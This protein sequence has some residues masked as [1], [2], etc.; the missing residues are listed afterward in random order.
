MPEVIRVLVVDDHA[1]HRDGARGILS[2]H[3][4]IEVVDEADSG[5]MALA[6]IDRLLPDVVL[7]DIRLPGVSGIE[8]TRQIRA[9]NPSVRVLMVSAYD[10][11]EY[12][13]GALQAGASGYLCKTAPGREL[14]KAIRSVASGSTVVEPAV[15]ARLLVVRPSRSST[16]GGLSER[17]QSVLDLLAQGLTNKRVAARLNISART[18]ERHCESIYAK[19]AVHSRAEAV[20]SGFASGLLRGRHEE[21]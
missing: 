12:I 4:D 20:I 10:D 1:L 16:E 17:E 15:L 21:P 18:V 8:A 13:R 3:P 14:A 7:M 2:Q 11:D 5:E 19:M 6:L 9:R